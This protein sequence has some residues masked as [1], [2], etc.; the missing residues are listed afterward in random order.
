MLHKISTIKNAEMLSKETQA[1]INGGV[2]IY[3]DRDSDCPPNWACSAAG[4]CCP[5]HY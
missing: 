2:M 5:D 1:K 3:C 4:F